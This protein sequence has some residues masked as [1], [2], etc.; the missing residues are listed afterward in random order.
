M[1]PGAKAT[2]SFQRADQ[3]IWLC[4][5]P[6]RR[7]Y[8]DYFLPPPTLRCSASIRLAREKPFARKTGDSPCALRRRR[9]VEAR[10]RTAALEDFPKAL[11]QRRPVRYLQAATP[12]PPAN[13]KEGEEKSESS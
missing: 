10:M 7:H 6:H 12:P 13:G 4:T 3:F 11:T 8:R 5:R 9:Q 2:R 1:A